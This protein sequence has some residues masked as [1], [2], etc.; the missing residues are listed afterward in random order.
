MKQI[1]IIAVLFFICGNVSAQQERR[2]RIK[3]LKIAFITEK[4]ALSSSEAQK[5]WPIYNTYD[6]NTYRLKNVDLKKIKNELRIKGIDA[7]SEQE[8][9]SILERIENI[10]ASIYG[11]RRKLVIN[12]SNAI[13]AKKIILLKKVEDDF[14]RELLKRLRERRMNRF[15]NRN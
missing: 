14:N 13:S 3:S 15:Q 7:I 2:E 11:E 6:D 4:L 8:A 10:E 5:F 12:L 9:K 1:C